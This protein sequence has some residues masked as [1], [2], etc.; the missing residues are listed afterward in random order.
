MSGVFRSPHGLFACQ[1]EGVAF[2][3]ARSGLLIADTGLGKSVMA[4]AIAALFKEDHA[5]H[6]VLLVCKNNKTSEWAEDFDT[7]TSL[8]HRLHHGSARMKHLTRDGLPDVLI[9]TYETLRADLA[10]FTVPPGRRTKRAEDG[11]LLHCLLSA[12]ADGRRITVIYDE[13]SDK[14][15]NRSSAL[16]K[17]HAHA[18]TRLRTVQPDLRVIGL[19]ATP[20]S[21]GYEDAFNVLRLL[22][23]DAMPTIGTFT[24]IVI[25]ARDDY[26][27]PRYR[28]EGVDAFLKLARPHFWRK[29]KTDPDVQELFPAKIEEFRT[30]T[31]GDAQDALYRAVAELQQP[32]EP[33]VPGL[34]VA[35]RQIAA[36]PAALIQSARHGSSHLATQLVDTMGE[37][38][39]RQVPSAKADELVSYLAP[40]IHAQ[41]DKAVVFSFFGPSV[42]PLLAEV[43]RKEGIRSHLYHAAMTD[44]ER[45]TARTAFRADTGACVF[46][47]SDAGKDGI[48]LP[49][50]SYVIEYESATTFETRVQRFGRIDRVTS[51]APCI[52]CT[53]LVLRETVEEDLVGAMLARNEMTDHLL[54]DTGAKGHRTAWERRAAFVRS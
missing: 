37:E 17:A 19:T 23:P 6:L 53:T 8:T 3:Y 38:T 5:A 11:A 48:N 29:R 33:A 30:V 22:V 39:L 16:Y 35:L 18:L 4:M 28:P 10:Q 32:G 52:T 31:M 36:Y 15:R 41:G 14:L 50:A 24:S 43:L 9:S 21:Q 34:H 20:L 1:Q 13:V 54:G 51:T 25:K 12:L 47:T 49:E 27:R 26:G 46:L 42:L 7:F 40:I 45:D 44:A 2:G